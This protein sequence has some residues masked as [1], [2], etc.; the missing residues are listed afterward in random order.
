M[1]RIARRSL[2]AVFAVP[3]GLALGCEQSNRG[4]APTAGDD[5]LVVALQADGKTLDPH[6]ATDAASMRLCENLYATLLRYGERYGEIEPGLARAYQVSDDGRTW[7]FELRDN[8]FF[9]G[10]ARAVTAE[11]VKFS[12]RRIVEK[13]VRADQ[14][15]VISRIDT[16][17]PH[18]VVLHLQTAFSPLESALA[19]PMNAI[20]DREVVEKSGDN[21]SRS[22]AGSGPFRLVEWVTARH[23]VMKRDPRYWERGL[24]RVERV[25]FRP[26]PDETAR[27]TALR[28]GEVDLSLDV[29]P[30]DARE[31]DSVPGITL[32]SV[33]GTFWEYIGLNTKRPPFDDVRVRKAV[34][35]AVDRRQIATLVKLG[36]ARVLD[37]GPIPEGHWA[38]ADLHLYPAPDPARARA[39][40]AE[41]GK[42]ELS[43]TLKVGAEFPYQV[44][45]A[46]VVKRQLGKIGIT[47]HI[48]VE[49]STLFFNSL[50][51]GEF[52]MTLVGWVGFVDADEW[53]YALFHSGGRYNQQGFANAEVDRLLERGRVLRDRAERRG[54]YRQAQRIIA[55]QAPMVFL[56]Q[57]PQI[58]AWRSRVHG[59]VVHP[60]A[61]TEFLRRTELRP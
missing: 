12:L 59:Y 11:D 35:W 38:Y 40:L 54:V 28:S 30:R 41:A 31:L 39:L 34:A 2:L 44:N 56:Y 61:T 8:V 25:V 32:G 23:L 14:L 55:E 26:I 21:L 45:A 24:P 58:S 1:Q 20:V 36:R 42:P 19:H 13:G 51:H 43:V 52:E 49:R 6:L 22:D 16:P 48:R 27:T 17:D 37:G 29:P 47:V 57:N 46:Q 50:G 18:R 53:L 5:T 3:F 7:T 4:G 60:T 10:S 15:K 9:H 33:P